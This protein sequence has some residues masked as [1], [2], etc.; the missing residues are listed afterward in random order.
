MKKLSYEQVKEYVEQQGC[1]F[2]SDSYTNSSTKIELKCSK[3]HNFSMTWRDFNSGA[4]CPICAGNSKPSYEYVKK[5]IENEGYVLLSD[6]YINARAKLEILCPNG[7]RCDKTWDKFKGQDRRCGICANNIKYTYEY[8]KNYIEQQNYTLVSEKYGG[9]KVRLSVKCSNNHITDI[10][11]DNFKNKKYR[12]NQCSKDIYKDEKECRRIF[13]E[14]TG[15]GFPSK[16]PNFL[17]NPKTGFN[18]ELDGYCEELKLA[19]E[20][21]G[22]QHFSSGHWGGSDGFQI[23]LSND[24]LKDSLCIKH[25]II[26]IR[27]PFTAKNRKYEFILEKMEQL[28]VKKS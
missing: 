5:Y 14:I 27:I 4:R 19:F 28:N 3:E 17:K 10:F 26:L 24:N 16:R 7:H 11:F 21:D 2:V 18:L 8:I 25:G 20:Y 15:Y 6:S 23:R 13:E 1:T 12:C 22:E 9:S